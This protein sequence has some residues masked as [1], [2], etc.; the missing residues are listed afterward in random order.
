[1]SEYAAFVGWDWADQEHE[2]RMREVGGTEI[3]KTTLEGRPEAIHQWAAQMRVRFEGRRVA[4]CLEA[5][6]A[7]VVW[8]LMT[9]DHLV[10]YLVNPVSVK[11][12]RKT[13]HPSGKKDDPVD[14]EIAL[15]LVEKHHE[16]LRS[17]RPADAETR[18]MALLSEHA[19]K[20]TSDMTRTKN[21]LRANLK[22]FYPQAL[23]LV[24]DLDTP[25]ACD[26]LE[27]WPTL[28]QLKRARPSTIRKFYVE[29]NSRCNELIEQRLVLIQEATELTSDEA[30]L[31][32]G[33]L[34]TR[35]LIHQIRGTRQAMQ[36]IDAELA[37]LY[38]AHPEH[39]L[40][41]SFPGAGSKLGPRLVALLGS[42]RD[43]FESANDLQKI[44]GMA[45]ITIRTGGRNGT[46]SVYRRVVRSKFL[47]QTV[48]E[49]AACTVPQSEWA[50]AFYQYEIERGKTRWAA[51][52]ALGYKLLRILFQCWQTRTKYDE[53]LYQQ[54][55][56]RRGSP[57]AG[58][59]TN[60]A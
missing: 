46:A 56:I 30:I 29:H 27:R 45:P 17:L 59:L 22:K 23:E 52:R 50:R 32:S 21:R 28:G 3:E 36:H 5:C 10:L 44:T 53:Q 54:A 11:S 24:G 49:W 7:G 26:F 1:M 31:C 51:L 42:D 57:I 15:E 58:R 41:D 4:V 48:V 55:L 16:K 39:D 20:L 9:Y 2:I 47:H 34:I 18:Q 40:I 35:T 38:A 33:E 19:R 14:A 13:F 25:M 12:F 6:R 37:R 60:A 43:R 8:A